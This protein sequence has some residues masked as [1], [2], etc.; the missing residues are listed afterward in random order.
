[1]NE[2]I[3]LFTDERLSRRCH[4]DIPEAHV[5]HKMVEYYGDRLSKTERG[6]LQMQF[7]DVENALALSRRR[8]LYAAELIFKMIADQQLEYP[9]FMRNGMLSIV[10]AAAS[11]YVYACGRIEESMELMEQAIRYSMTQSMDFPFILTGSQQ[12]W[13]NIVVVRSRQGDMD[14]AFS[15]LNALTSFFLTGEASGMGVE[16][17]FHFDA[18]GV[19]CDRFWQLEPEL[20]HDMICKITGH[21]FGG[22]LRYCHN[23]FSLAGNYY[24]QLIRQA[25][26]AMQGRR[27]IQWARSPIMLLHLFYT[28]QRERFLEG[29]SEQFDDILQAAPPL[30]WLI[31]SNYVLL[32]REAG[33]DLES[34]PNYKRFF[35]AYWSL[36]INTELLKPVAQEMG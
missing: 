10:K 15:E 6:L 33:F 4:E 27:V 32:F 8:E 17:R 20:Q 31:I 25:A 26:Y 21:A 36:G 34:H 12:Q 18:G 5:F 16:E 22:L 1:M 13:L 7:E 9:E 30:Q 23:D 29:I 19:I 14:S 24:G 2:F 35:E 11:Y 28:G 3:E